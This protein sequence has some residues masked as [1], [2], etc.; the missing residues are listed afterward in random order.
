M[1]RKKAK[2][3]VR[4]KKEQKGAIDQTHDTLVKLHNS[5]VDDIYD[6]FKSQTCGSCLEMNEKICRVHDFHLADIQLDLFDRFRCD[7]Y[8]RKTDGN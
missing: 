7:E 4:P 6:D 2:W 8:K 5:V 3:R 1:N